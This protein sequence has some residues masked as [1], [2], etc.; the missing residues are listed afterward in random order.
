MDFKRAFKPTKN[1]IQATIRQYGTTRSEKYL[2]KCIE[3]MQH[4]NDPE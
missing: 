3:W 2:E 1:E 4:I